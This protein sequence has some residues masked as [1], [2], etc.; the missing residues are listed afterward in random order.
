MNLQWC[1]F[2]FTALFDEHVT[3]SS[4]AQCLLVSDSW[5]LNWLSWW[6]RNKS[7]LHTQA[8]LGDLALFLWQALF[9]RG[10]DFSEYV[11]LETMIGTFDNFVLVSWEDGTNCLFSWIHWHSFTSEFQVKKKKN[12]VHVNRHFPSIFIPINHKWQYKI[13]ITWLKLVRV[14][15]REKQVIREIKDV[16]AF[17]IKRFR[18]RDP[19]RLTS[20]WS[21]GPWRH[22]SSSKTIMLLGFAN[23]HYEYRLQ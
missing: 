10:P 15:L 16:T 14:R 22:T 21:P 7:L 13:R 6:E 1:F 18:A 12:C 5:T 23:L 2:F 8:L 19:R 17:V 9:S 4:S 3:S 20:P 11:D